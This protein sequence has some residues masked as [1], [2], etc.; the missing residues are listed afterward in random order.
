[1]GVELVCDLAVK[2]KLTF[3][4][5]RGS[6]VNTAAAGTIINRLLEW[7]GYYKGIAVTDN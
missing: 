6:E 5:W 1:L 7:V 2:L 4:E 3:D